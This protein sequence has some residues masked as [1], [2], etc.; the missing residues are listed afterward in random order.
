M[1]G[2][3][4]ADDGV[5]SVSVSQSGVELFRYVYQSTAAQVESP[6]PFVHPL[7]TLDGRLVSIGRPHDHRWHVGLAWSL[8]HF[9]DENFWGG[10]S[11]RAGRGYVQLENNGAIR[12]RRTDHVGLSG[13]S[14]EFRHTLTWY[15]QN[16][17][18]VVDERRA[19]TARVVSADA[20]VMTFESSMDNTSGRDVTI[21]SPTTEGRP[22]AGYGGLF[23]RGP[24]SFTG[25]KVLGPDGSSGESL[26][27]T[28][29][30]WM[31]F[32]GAHD[33]QDGSS[34]VVILDDEANAQHPPQ[35]FTRTEPF[36][37]LG[38]APFFS[39]EVTFGSDTTM[40]NRYAVVIADGTADH[41]Q[42]AHLSQLGSDVLHLLPSVR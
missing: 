20:W 14:F 26:R 25:G 39:T 13:D 42:A 15:R 7:R 36:G 37:C 30:P 31:C 6:R 19:I 12:H 24:R 27:G 1:T 3:T 29:A 9:G 5:H 17:E 18:A 40:T 32:T 33:E 2:F 10:P 35:W 21:G 22:D 16:G 4:W 34:T 23:W 8:P 28:R 11:F 41:K 38:P